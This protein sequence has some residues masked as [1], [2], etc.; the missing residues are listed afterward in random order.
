MAT[1]KTHDFINCS[2]LNANLESVNNSSLYPYNG[3]VLRFD[4][5]NLK[6]YTLKK[7]VQ[8]RFYAFPDWGGEFGTPD[9]EY[10][11]TSMKFN[12]VELLSAPASTVLD[13]D[14]V[15][16]TSW[17]EY[18]SGT[19]YDYTGNKANGVI[20][21]DGS[22]DGGHGTNNLYLLAQQLVTAH[23]PNESVKISRSP[24]LWWSND[25]FNRIPN[26]IIE[27][28]YDDDFEMTFTAAYNSTTAEYKYVFNEETVEYYV[29]GSEYEG[30][31]VPQFSDSFS[32]Y[33]YDFVYNTLE[34]LPNCP[35]APVVSEQFQ[36]SLQTNGCSN[37][38]ID[39]E[40]TTLTFADNSNYL[41][42]DM[43]GHGSLDF[44]FRVITLTRPDGTT[45]VYSTVDADGV[46]K[47][48]PPNYDSSNQ[49]AYIFNNTDTDGVYE[50]KLCTYPDWK[51]DV[52]YVST[53]QDIVY[54]SGSLYKSISTSYNIDPA[55]DTTN[56]Y[57]MP[58]TC[59]G[60][61]TDTR[62]CTKEKIAV[63][64]ISLLECYKQM[65]KNAF[66]GIESNPCSNM[67][68]NKEFMQA[69]KFRITL[70]ALEL[71]VTA[72]DWTSAARQFEILNSICCC[73]D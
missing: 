52:E 49:F 11:I 71:S 39:C 14:T 8:G 70:D 53:L 32:F 18:V 40:C 59:I 48:I 44:N 1:V 36:S 15:L 27:K 56:T 9:I 45:Y 16:Y 51:D 6:T 5:S 55:T 47:V 31:F 72:G 24:E 30:A 41:T 25:E 19:E 58:Y 60:D 69:M 3:T 2:S 17:P 26:I 42:N 65:V 66:C 21:A 20:V 33:S 67:C 62:Y 4:S 10:T 57:W 22:V 43:P 54:R 50:V 23:I 38:E 13:G 68:D 63:L 37:L 34:E 61:C 46:D 28:R 64:C 29:D 35:T 12:G 7:L 73:N